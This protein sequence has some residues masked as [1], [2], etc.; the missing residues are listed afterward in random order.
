MLMPLLHCTA[1]SSCGCTAVD[2]AKDCTCCLGEI[3]LI[4]A[5]YLFLKLNE[6]TLW[7]L[8]RVPPTHAP[9]EML[10]SLKA[11]SKLKSNNNGLICVLE[12]ARCMTRRA[13]AA[14]VIF[15]AQWLSAR[16]HNGVHAEPLLALCCILKTNKKL[17]IDHGAQD[18]REE[19]VKCQ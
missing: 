16:C 13:R 14:T 5:M 15:H 7:C 11:R 8:I 2:S 4:T 19:S 3:R 10:A 18:R 17:N 1:C 12:P 9:A 6:C